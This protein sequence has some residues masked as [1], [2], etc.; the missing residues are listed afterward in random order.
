MGTSRS[1]FYFLAT[2]IVA[3]KLTNSYTGRIA[4]VSYIGSLKLPNLAASLLQ[5]KSKQQN[6]NILVVQKPTQ[7]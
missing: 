5:T 7:S 1:Y 4:L 6:N 3:A 2:K